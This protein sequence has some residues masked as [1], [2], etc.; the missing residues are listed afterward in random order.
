[1]IKLPCEV[2]IW[3]FLPALRR[4]LVKA[5]LKEGVSRK[6]IASMLGIT[7]SAISQYLKKKRGMHFRFG[8]DIKQRIQQIARHLKNTPVKNRSARF[9]AEICKFCLMLKRK[10]VLCSLCLKQNPE[11]NKNCNVV[12]RIK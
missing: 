4:E 11:L 1:M 10:K 3:E 2:M 8:V 5:L 9:I 6:E 12:R 7:D